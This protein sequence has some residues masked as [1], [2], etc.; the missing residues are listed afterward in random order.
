MDISSVWLDDDFSRKELNILEIV[1]GTIPGD[2]G[3]PPL[4]HTLKKK[5][6]NE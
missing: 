4:I 2:V 6:R 1:R 5:Y 3:V